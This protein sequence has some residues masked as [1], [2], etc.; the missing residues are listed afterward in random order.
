MLQLDCSHGGLILLDDRHVP[1][2]FRPLLKPRLRLLLLD[3][4][5]LSNPQILAVIEKHFA[6]LILLELY[7][8]PDYLDGVDLLEVIPYFV[9][10]F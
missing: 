5:K 2:R 7:L 6:S 9:T 8:H 10:H 3:L 1:P 4:L